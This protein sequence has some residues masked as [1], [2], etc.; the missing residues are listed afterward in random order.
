MLFWSSGLVYGEVIILA[1]HSAQYLFITHVT[2]QDIT[3][4]FRA[5]CG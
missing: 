2:T 4:V 3:S 5:A 1:L